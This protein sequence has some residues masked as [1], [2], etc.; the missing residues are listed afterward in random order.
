MNFALRHG[1]PLELLSSVRVRAASRTRLSGVGILTPQSA[2]RTRL[3]AF[4][5]PRLPTYCRAVGARGAYRSAAR[6]AGGFP[7]LGD[8]G[9]RAGETG[10]RR[11]PFSRRA[12]SA[13]GSLLDL[14]PR[15]PQETVRRRS[16]S[17][18]GD[19]IQHAERAAIYRGSSLRRR[20]VCLS[21]SS[22]CRTGRSFAHR[23]RLPR[24][25]RFPFGW[26]TGGRQPLPTKPIC[27]TRGRSRCST[28]SPLAPPNASS[29]QRSLGTPPSLEAGNRTTHFALRCGI[30][31]TGPER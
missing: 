23:G 30:S 10:T 20:S 21:D 11:I 9:S 18:T 8:R 17:P 16:G 29:P 28:A 2:L 26:A 13:R 3:D 15:W 5:A 14:G 25:P 6:C 4:P 1:C 19:P 22:G 7:G 12:G 27:S 24:A 31:S